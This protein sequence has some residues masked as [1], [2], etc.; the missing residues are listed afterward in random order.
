MAI[1]FFSGLELEYILAPWNIQK[2]ISLKS[3]DGL[4][5]LY[6][7]LDDEVIPLKTF[8]W[9][10]A[11]AR[12]FKIHIKTVLKKNQKFKQK[13]FRNIYVPFD[14]QFKISTYMYKEW[15]Q[16][17]HQVWCWSSKGVKSYLGGNTLGAKE[18]FNLIFEHVTWKS[19]DIIY[20]MRVTPALR[21]VLIK[22]RGQKILSRQHSGLRRV[23]WTWPLNM[24]PEKINR[25]HLLIEGNPCTKFGIDQVKG[26]K[27]IKQR[28][29]WAEK[30]GLR[31]VVWPWPL[32]M[33]PE[34]Q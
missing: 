10:L 23:V 13:S 31:R 21:L 2:Q 22:W 6:R 20:S 17:L 28:T 34:N 32:N 14:A 11:K 18:W 5:F 16:P 3:S 9:S 19:K 4:I 24:W 1:I 25:D 33:W 12:R 15:V 27:D 26:S 29:H 30:S 8:A 7:V